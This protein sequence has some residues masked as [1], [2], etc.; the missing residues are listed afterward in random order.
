M[1]MTWFPTNHPPLYGTVINPSDNKILHNSVA[2]DPQVTTCWI[3]VSTNK[4]NLSDVKQTICLTSGRNINF[5][6][7]HREDVNH[8]M[9]EGQQTT[10]KIV[11]SI[12][13]LSKCI[14]SVNTYRILHT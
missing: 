2:L 9:T 1:D 4:A 3:V 10:E 13:P 8:T 5:S 11:P 14:E 7:N 12:I 6:T